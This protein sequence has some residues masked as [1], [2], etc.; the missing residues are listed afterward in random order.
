M[1]G[2]SSSSSRNIHVAGKS[3]GRVRGMLHG[4]VRGKEEELACACC[5]C[6]LVAEYTK[7]ARV[8]A[9]GHALPFKRGTLDD[10]GG[11]ANIAT[12]DVAIGEKRR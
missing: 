2:S 10:L 9:P 7:S 6:M 8:V 3:Y 12:G 4:R 11:G 1:G 5:M